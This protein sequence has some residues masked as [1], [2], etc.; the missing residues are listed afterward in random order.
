MK[1]A[2]GILKN[3]SKPEIDNLNKFM[4]IK[5]EDILIEKNEKYNAWMIV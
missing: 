3:I 2:N 5:R 4:N 1:F